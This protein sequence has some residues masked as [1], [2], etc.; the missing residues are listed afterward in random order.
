MKTL[1]YFKDKNKAFTEP[2]YSTKYWLFKRDDKRIGVNKA[3]SLCKC[4]KEI[5]ELLEKYIKIEKF[6]KPNLHFK[7][8]SEYGK[9]FQSFCDYKLKRSR[10][11]G[12]GSTPK[13]TLEVGGGVLSDYLWIGKTYYD[14]KDEEYLINTYLSKFYKKDVIFNH[15]IYMDFLNM[16]EFVKYFTDCENELASKRN[17][18]CRISS[19]LEKEKVI[20]CLY[21]DG[22]IDYHSNNKVFELKCSSKISY[23]SA[24]EQC[25]AYACM[26]I[27]RAFRYDL[28]GY[29][30]KEIGV[31]NTILGTYCHMNLDEF[32]QDNLEKF[33]EL[34]FREVI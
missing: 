5:R 14:I 19:V 29:D 6:D 33:C 32:G 10:Y 2:L 17:V 12:D 25:L 18:T 3:I 22:E 28:K 24:I 34:F 13:L 20:K 8:T 21:F 31:I 27:D 7:N 16:V 1:E 30:I 26:L 4:K 23:T 15:E 11:L 9:L